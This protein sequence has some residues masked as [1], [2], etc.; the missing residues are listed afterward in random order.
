[1][2]ASLYLSI[3]VL[4]AGCFRPGPRRFGQPFAA[5]RDRVVAVVASGAIKIDART[6]IRAASQV[7]PP[8]E[9]GDAPPPTAARHEARA[10]PPPAQT[11]TPD[12]QVSHVTHAH[13]TVFVL[14]GQTYGGQDLCETHSTLDDC[15][16]ACTSMLRASSLSKPVD[17]TP[18]SC[19]CTELD[20]GC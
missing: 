10:T 1:M 20:K 16:S 2:R 15:N 5:V 14:R 17:S 12:V 9:A 6:A 8:H 11:P 7:P 4:V 13:S 19:A 18:K 3:V